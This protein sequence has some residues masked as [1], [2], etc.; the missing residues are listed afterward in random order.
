MLRAMSTR[1]VAAS[2]PL[3]V[4]LRRKLGAY[5]VD[6]AFGGLSRLGRIHPRLRAQEA[7]TTIERD[8]AYR[9]GGGVWHK[10][11][12]HRPL[13]ARGPLPIVLYV[14]GGGFRI[15]SKDTHWIMALAFARKGYVVFNIDYRLAPDHPYPA[16]IEDAAHALLWASRNAERFGG[17][18]RRIVLAGESAGANL[19]T[20][21]AI[22]T[23]WRR[24]EPFARALFDEG[25]RPRAVVAACG[26]HEVSN[27]ERFHRRGLPAVL[28]D[29]VEE[30]RQ[31][32]LDGAQADAPGGF[33]LADPVVVLERAEAPERPLPPFY[34][35][36]GTRDLLLDD[37]RRLARALDRL[38]ARCIDRY[39]DGE[40][41]AFQAF[42]WRKNAKTCWR[43]THAFLE[44]ALRDA[45]EA[46]G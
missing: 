30:V 17:D 18:P 4:R 19:V 13:E 39:F 40:L 28:L 34:A 12:V 45:V 14:H 10:L 9:D 15:L 23:S 5:V 37:T 35:A 21:L 33:E 6:N 22:A 1:P 7:R 20:S 27:L 11:D 43:E 16:A 29:R 42:L 44:E 46:A 26:M 32:Y 3:R 25:I 8:V 36:V 24:P 38:G 31:A 41:H 2:D